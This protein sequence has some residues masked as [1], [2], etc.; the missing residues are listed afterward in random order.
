MSKFRKNESKGTPFDIFRSNKSRPITE[1]ER[2]KLK[3][4]LQTSIIEVETQRRL[5]KQRIERSILKARNAIQN[6]GVS[7]KAIAYNELRMNLAF[8]R[9]MGTL[10][11]NLSMME[12]NLSIQTITENFADIVHRMSRL[13]APANTMNFNKLT[14]EALRG[15]HP[16]Q[17]DGIEDLAKNLIESSLSASNAAMIEDK[18]LEDLIIGRISLDDPIDAPSNSYESSTNVSAADS[19]SHF[20]TT[21]TS[22]NELMRMLDEI[23]TGL[24]NGG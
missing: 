21:D 1:E 23:S 20:S 2:D 5:A 4:E 3:A 16:V 22:T 6:N 19:A 9:Y 8:Y 24:R 15:I 7:Q 12:S 17:L 13:K 11:S 10:G 14:A 18:Y